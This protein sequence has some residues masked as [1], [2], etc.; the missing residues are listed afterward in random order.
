MRIAITGGT[1]FVGSHLT[2][3]LSEQGHELVLLTRTRRQRRATRPNVTLVG[4][5]VVTGEGLAEGL[6]GCDALVHLV[7]VIVERG[8]QTFDAVNRRGSANVAAAARRAGIGHLVHLSAVGADPDPRYAY[9]ASKWA[10][11]QAVRISGV[12]H[13]IIRSSLMFGPGDGFFTKLTKLVRRTPP[14][15]P[16]P[17]AGDGRT[18]F[19]PIAVD[20]VAR[21]IATALE[22]GPSDRVVSIGGPD[23]LSY[24]EIIDIIKAKVV[25]LPR[26]NV[27]VPV[28]AIKPMAAMM[29]AVMRDPLVTPSQLDLLGR[30]NITT[31]NAVA[32]AFGFT[33]RRFADNCAY[34]RDY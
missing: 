26:I 20:D 19:Q 4:A 25:S 11:E 16:L 21:C 34:L 27:H 2:A 3:Q 13:T 31:P 33:P 10:G 1:G 7:A 12:P 30:N 9:L 18:L 6:A 15:A 32:T 8:R 28:L 17:V 24:E 5:D 14:M 23:H 22:R 29:A